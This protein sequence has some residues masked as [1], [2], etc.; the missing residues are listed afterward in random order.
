MRRDQIGRQTRL[1][2]TAVVL[3]ACVALFA[4]RDFHVAG[5]WF[6]ISMFAALIG[7][8]VWEGRREIRSNRIEERRSQGLCTRCGYDLRASLDRC[9]ECGTTVSRHS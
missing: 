4:L 1:R 2:F 7:F 6:A 8:F 5:F 3:F 9:P